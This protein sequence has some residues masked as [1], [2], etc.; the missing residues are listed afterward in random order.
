MAAQVRLPCSQRATFDD[1]LDGGDG[2][3]GFIKRDGDGRLFTSDYHSLAV[4]ESG[5]TF[6]SVTDV[7]VEHNEVDAADAKHHQTTGI[8]DAP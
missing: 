2:R 5:G 1:F 6:A 7:V 3:P 4:D 8:T